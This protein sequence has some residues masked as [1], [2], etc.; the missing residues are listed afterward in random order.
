[1]TSWTRRQNS[2]T[3]WWRRCRRLSFSAGVFD[4]FRFFWKIFCMKS[5]FFSWRKNK[6]TMNNHNVGQGLLC[7]SFFSPSLFSP[8]FLAFTASWRQ[9][10]IPRIIRFL[11]SVVCL[12]SLLHC[13]NANCHYNL[14]PSMK[15]LTSFK[16]IVPFA[17]LEIIVFFPWISIS[18]QEFP[19][20]IECTPFR[21]ILKILAVFDPGSDFPW[22]KMMFLCVTSSVL[23]AQFPRECLI[24]LVYMVT[25]MSRHLMP[26]QSSTIYCHDSMRSYVLPI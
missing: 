5:V 14:P 19:P 13:A 20:C 16:R 6:N 11:W 7:S 2:G 25:L 21:V 3:C 22:S 9:T 12:L 10:D 15:M 26:W 4:A 8:L 17:V 24:F 23:G 18:A 1:M